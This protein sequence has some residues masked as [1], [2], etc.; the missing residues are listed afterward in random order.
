MSRQP[1]LKTRRLILRA[2][3][4]KDV[5][6]LQRLAARREIADTTISVPHPYSE[7]DAREFISR[8]RGHWNLGREAAFAIVT[9]KDNQVV[10]SVGLRDIDRE[11]SH[12]EMGA[13]IGVE[14]WGLGYATEASRAVLR[15]GFEALKLHRIHA[16]Y[17]LRNPASGRVL[18]KIGMKRE[19]ILRE[20][21]RKWGIFEDVAVLAFLRRD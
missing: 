17:M 13:W 1:S 7:R 11:H 18:E 12:A 21:V 14:F 19:G 15:F 9:R 6:A 10:G 8:S 4:T 20:A 16:H 5:P 3:R 2:W